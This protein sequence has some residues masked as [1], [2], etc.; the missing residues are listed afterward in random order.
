MKYR[1]QGHAVY[2]AHYHI[3]LCARYRRKIFRKSMGEYLKKSV[4]GITRVYPDIVIK[5][6]N[7]DLVVANSFQGRH[8]QGY[9]LDKGQNILFEGKSRLSISQGLTKILCRQK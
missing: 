1:K 9:V 3:V 8:Y 5:E 6:A 2:C 4:H 7:C